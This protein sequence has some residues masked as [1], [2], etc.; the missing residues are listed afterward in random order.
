M[1]TE[2]FEISNFIRL[3]KLNFPFLSIQTVEDKKSTEDNYDKNAESLRQ[4]KEN[5]EWLCNENRRLYITSN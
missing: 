1:N 3:V 2:H 5:S 4:T